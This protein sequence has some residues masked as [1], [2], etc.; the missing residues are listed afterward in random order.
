LGIPNIDILNINSRYDANREYGIEA[1]REEKK[2]TGVWI[3][4]EKITAM[5]IAVK[6]WVTMHGFA[7]NVNT[8]LDHFKWIIPCGL[9]NR[10]VTSLEKITGMTQDFERLNSLVINYFCQVFELERETVSL[11]S[12]L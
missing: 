7:F 6:R 10:G 12:L 5:G 4:E 2:F 8:N 9:A 11:E 1:H 3:G